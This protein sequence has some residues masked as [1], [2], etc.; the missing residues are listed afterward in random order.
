MNTNKNNLKKMTD[1]ERIAARR[2]KFAAALRDA[3]NRYDAGERFA[4]HISN[5]NSKTGAVASVST[6]PLLTCP[7]CCKEQCGAKCY[8]AKIAALRPSVLKAYAENTALYIRDPRAYFDGIRAAVQAVRFFRWHVSGDIINKRYF[9]EMCA[10]AAAA[11]WCRF[12]VFTKRAD[13]VNG[14]LNDGGVIPSNLVV[15]FSTWGEWTP[16]NTYN[17]PVS[18]VIFNGCE[19]CENWKICGGNCFE[20][21]CRGVGCWELQH[22]ET[23]AFYEH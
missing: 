11:P 3:L 16:E 4:V 7:G 6:L 22:G 2:E 14:Y 15:I 13:A 5:G 21:A 8:A 23:I 1:A 18:A 19:P 20:C 12:M 9:S 17:L 10:V